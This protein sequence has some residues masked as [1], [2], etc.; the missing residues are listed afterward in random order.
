[1]KCNNSISKSRN[2]TFFNKKLQN[3]KKP[4]PKLGC[5]GSVNVDVHVTMTLKCSQKK[6]KVK[7]PTIGGHSLN[8]FEVI[9]LFN[10]GGR[11]EG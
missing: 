5:H 1:M 7:V 6:S 2:D 10:D 8:V 11:G 3:V 9:Q 4:L